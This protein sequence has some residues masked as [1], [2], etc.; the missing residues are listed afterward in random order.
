MPLTLNGA[1]VETILSCRN[2]IRRTCYF[3]Q[4]MSL[5]TATT[6]TGTNRSHISNIVSERLP[7][8]AGLAHLW[9]FTSISVGSSPRSFSFT[10]TSVTLSLHFQDRCGKAS[11]RYRNHTE[12]TVLMCKQIRGPIRYR[13]RVGAGAIPYNLNITH[14]L[15]SRGRNFV[16]MIQWI[17][18]SRSTPSTR[19]NAHS[20]NWLV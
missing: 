15:T 8:Y 3:D 2:L 1:S 16:K 5:W 6:L 11:F 9:I 4:A 19:K 12:I 13:F 20:L 14:W 18:K 17:N 10:S 7:R